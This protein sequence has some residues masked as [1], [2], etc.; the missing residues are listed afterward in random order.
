MKAVP[1]L[2]MWLSVILVLLNVVMLNP[3]TTSASSDTRNQQSCTGEWTLP[4]LYV[5]GEDGAVYAEAAYE[6]DEN[7]KPVLASQVRLDYVP[8][9]VYE[10]SQRAVDVR[11][12]TLPPSARN[13]GIGE[14]AM[15]VNTCHLRTYEEDVIGLDM[16]AV[17]TDQTYSWNNNTVSLANGATSATTYFSWWFLTSGPTMSNGYHNSQLAW[18]RGS[19]GFNCNG[20]PFCQ[21]GPKYAIVLSTDIS[22]DHQGGCGGFGS[23]AGT[24]V[25]GGQVRYSVWRD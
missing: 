3:T 12:I 4:P 6:F 7:C 13:E 22:M 10:S 25:P 18:A 2:A 24:V 23:A 21:G 14:A 15:A 20:G 19:A 1:R 17:Q 16:I 11:T 5:G 8:A 9:S